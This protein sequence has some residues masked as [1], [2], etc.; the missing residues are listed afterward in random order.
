VVIFVAEK[1]KEVEKFEPT[2]FKNKKTDLVLQAGTEAMASD[3]EK[4]NDFE[5]IEDPTKKT[6]AKK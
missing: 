4:D 6:T 5:A 3:L 2:W 1:A